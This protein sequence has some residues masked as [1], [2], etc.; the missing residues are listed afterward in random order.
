MNNSILWYQPEELKEKDV[1]VVNGEII[2]DTSS[3][4]VKFRELKTYADKVLR[5]KTPW[6]GKVDGV[7][8]LKGFL[9]GADERGR[10]LS[11]M[12]M[13]DAPQQEIVLSQALSVI[14]HQMDESTQKCFEERGKLPK[15]F[16]YSAIGVVIVLLIVIIISYYGE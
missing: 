11:F 8:F 7:F 12:F 14:S 3:R 9:A 4:S 1:L 15:S 13:S 2:N 6:C 10:Q 16:I 5:K